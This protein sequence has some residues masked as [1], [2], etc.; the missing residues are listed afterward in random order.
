MWAKNLF[1]FFPSRRF[2]Q[3]NPGEK[4]QGKKQNN[5]PGRRRVEQNPVPVPSQAPTEAEPHHQTF[6]MS[7][8]RI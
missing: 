7:S 3:K 5:V 8:R 2:L 6:G 1:F 4:I